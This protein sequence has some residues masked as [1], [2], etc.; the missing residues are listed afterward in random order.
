M[1]RRPRD[2]WPNMPRTT[3][4][5]ALCHS[6]H[7]MAIKPGFLLSSNTGGRGQS[8]RPTGW[9]MRKRSS[10]LSAMDM[11]PRM[12]ASAGMTACLPLAKITLMGNTRPGG[13]KTVQVSRDMS[14]GRKKPFRVRSIISCCKRYP[15]YLRAPLNQC[16]VLVAELSWWINEASP[17][18]SMEALNIVHGTVKLGVETDYEA[19]YQLVLQKCSTKG[20]II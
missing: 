9:T 1:M 7:I 18:F 10:L 17:G 8:G 6:T 13:T 2:I 4:G 3:I 14:V 15:F 12:S 5:L 20:V 19:L 16:T 11:A